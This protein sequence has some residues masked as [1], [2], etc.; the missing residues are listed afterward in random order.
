ML[1]IPLKLKLSIVCIVVALGTSGFVRVAAG[2]EVV[3]DL[4][5]DGQKE[6]GTDFISL[7]TEKPYL[8]SVRLGWSEQHPD[9]LLIMVGVEGLK[10]FPELAPDK[11]PLT[12]TPPGAGDALGWRNSTAQGD[13]DKQ[14]RR[15]MDVFGMRW[16]DFE[17]VFVEG[18]R[19]GYQ[20]RDDVIEY[21]L[22]SESALLQA[23][24]ALRERVNEARAPG[25]QVELSADRMEECLTIAA[26]AFADAYLKRHE[27]G[28]GVERYLQYAMEKDHHGMGP[29]R[30]REFGVVY[31]DAAGRLPPN[32]PREQAAEGW[33]QNVCR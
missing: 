12:F 14:N 3:N 10:S 13:I 11:A 33:R 1:R 29:E 19:I 32:L 27:E 16:A 28:W 30:A 15:R 8:L 25:S 22:W 6:F 26:D 4:G 20:L 24:D 5:R 7:T 17:Q 2:S 23:A 9:R 18:T 21:T 31:W